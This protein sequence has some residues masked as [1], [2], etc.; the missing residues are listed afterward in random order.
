MN[1][2]HKA[3]LALPALGLATCL[4]QTASAAVIGDFQFTADGDTLGWTA[5]TNSSTPADFDTAGGSLNGTVATG[6]DPILDYLDGLTKASTANW[7]TLILRVRETGEI[8]EAGS[9][10]T[11]IDAGPTAVPYNAVGTLAILNEGISPTTGVLAASSI[12]DSG[13]GFFTVTYDI[14]GFTADTID[15]IRVDPIGGAASNSN[16]Q[17]SGNIFEVDFITVNDDSPIP[18]PSSLALLGLGGLAMMR[19]RR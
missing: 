16:S 18:E 17:T 7:T 19:R 11:V 4:S 3:L 5:R 6:N 8:V 10:T 9:S 14:S 13:S 1:L 2:T 15:K 12:V